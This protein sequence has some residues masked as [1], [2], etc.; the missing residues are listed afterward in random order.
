MAATQEFADQGFHPVSIDTIAERCGVTKG[1]VYLHFRGKLEV[2]LAAHGRLEQLRDRELSDLPEAPRKSA[3]EEL[4]GLL[5][6]YLD[7][8]R[9][10]PEL[11]RLQQIL[12]TE[13]AREPAT[14]GR[15]G[16][17]TTYRNLRSQ[18]RALLQRGMRDGVIG[19]V[20][21]AASAF[22]I[23][24][25]LEGALDQSRAAP[26]DVAHFVED[27]LVDAWLDGLPK[28]PRRR[29]SKPPTAKPEG[30]GADFRPAF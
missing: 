25:L 10:H 28:P 30:E 4:R 20:D 12:D 5:R 1:A 17:R 21:A 16:L 18:T 19:P 7:F 27:G 2:F 8:H 29:S 3:R 14:T 9:R 23:V 13:L 26:D 6:A 11:R 24:A 22:G 15:D